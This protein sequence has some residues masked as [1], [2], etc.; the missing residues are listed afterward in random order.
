MKSGL[1]LFIYSYGIICL[2]VLIRA[3]WVIVNYGEIGFVVSGSVA[4]IGLLFAACQIEELP[5]EK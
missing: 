5:N 2:V 1:H 3:L 4:V